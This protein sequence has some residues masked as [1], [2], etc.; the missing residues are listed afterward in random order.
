MPHRLHK[1]NSTEENSSDDNVEIAQDEQEILSAD[2]YRWEWS[3]PELAK[4]DTGVCPSD[5]K[6][7]ILKDITPE[8]RLK[9][10]YPNSTTRSVGR[11][12]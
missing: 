7:A 12:S 5:I 1:K 11:Y 6:Q 9:N 3:N 2:T 8:L 10:H 4:A